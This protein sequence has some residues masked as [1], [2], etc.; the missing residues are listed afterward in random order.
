MTRYVVLYHAPLAVAQRFAQATPA[1]AQLG[2]QRWID[3]T[4][5]LGAA[6]LDPGQP[7]GQSRCVTASGVE[8]G[9]TDVVGMSIL[10]APSIDAALD[11]VRDHHHLDEGDGC[12]ITLLEEM[13]VPELSKPDRG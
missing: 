7:F 5:R 13:A 11:M 9:D 8:S 3:W 12:S 2:L 1:E 6:L 4:T 10:E